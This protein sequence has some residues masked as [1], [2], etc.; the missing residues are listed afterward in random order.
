MNLEIVEKSPA[1][2]RFEAWA[3]HDRELPLEK[4]LGLY[5]FADTHK[6]WIAWQAAEASCEPIT[7]TLLEAL[8]RVCT[9]E[10]RD[11]KQIDADWDN[12]RAAIALAKEQQDKPSTPDME[13]QYGKPA[14]AIQGYCCT[15]IRSDGAQ[16]YDSIAAEVPSHLQVI[17]LTGAQRNPNVKIGD[18]GRM[19]F[20]RERT[21]AF[22]RFVL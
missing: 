6:A 10:K 4:D 12:A 8:E 14:Y 20:V 19:E 1:R 18:M 16:K 11:S 5:R 13:S 21:H 7:Q 2:E 22:W 9:H 17:W 3:K 15:E